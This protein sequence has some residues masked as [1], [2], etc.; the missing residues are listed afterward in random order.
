VATHVKADLRARME[1]PRSVEDTVTETLRWAIES[2]RLA[3]GARLGQADLAEEL[4]VSRIPL[5]DAF[6]RLAS[7]GLI[8]LDSRRGARVVS[9]SP[10]DIAEIYEMRLLLETTCARYAVDN[11]DVTAATALVNLSLEMDRMADDLEAGPAVRLD[12]YSRLYAH[13]DRPRMRETILRLR[14]QVGRYHR[15]NPAGHAGHAH[16]ELRKAIRARN[17]ERAA[18]VVAAHLVEARDDLLQSLKKAST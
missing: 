10:A 5:R 4:G 11:L 6:R 3:P 13:A 7:E 2:G 15:L 16:V 14:S 8:D 18:E 12:F 9:L 17:G 1:P